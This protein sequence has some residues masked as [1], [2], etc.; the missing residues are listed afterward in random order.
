MHKSASQA[1]LDPKDYTVSGGICVAVSIVVVQYIP[2][3]E[4]SAKSEWEIWSL[5]QNFPL[6]SQ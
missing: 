2:T 1:P 5:E 3:A 4:E 6:T